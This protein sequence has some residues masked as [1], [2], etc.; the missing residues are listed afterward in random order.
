VLTRVVEVPPDRLEGWVERYLRTHP[1]AVLSAADGGL[2]LSEQSGAT[3]SLRPLAP[4]VP[5]GGATDR[6]LVTALAEHAAQPIVIALLLVRRGGY[7]VGIADGRT[8]VHSKVGGRYVQSRTAAGGWSQQRFAR[9]RAG[10]VDQLVEAAAQAWSALPR[11]PKPV[12]LVTGGDRALCHR[13]VR[14]LDSA[15]QLPGR[16]T[17]SVARHL[18]V[19]D[20]RLDVLRQAVARAQALIVTVREP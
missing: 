8:L 19:P 17:A 16:G 1:A 18:D 14:E 13:L 12:A 2:V 15:G 9:R 10:Q 20:P 6:L 11:A 3:A 4:F 5:S 7:A